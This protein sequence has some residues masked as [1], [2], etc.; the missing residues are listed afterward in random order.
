MLF[1]TSVYYS[2]NKIRQLFSYSF[3]V[4]CIILSNVYFYIV[5]SLFPFLFNWPQSKAS[6]VNQVSHLFFE[7]QKYFCSFQLFE[8]G[9]IHNVV[10]TLIYVM[11]LDVENNSIVSTLSNTVNIIAEIDNVDLTLFNVVNFNVDIHNIVSTSIWHCP[12]SLRHIT[13]I[14]TLRPHWKISWV[15]TN[16][17]KRLH[18]FVKFIKYI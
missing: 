15:L 8:N 4:P 7:A 9:H 14:T 16:V 3:H 13:L 11:K 5:R 17:A 12:T 6:V 18:N 10:S 1:V 2:I